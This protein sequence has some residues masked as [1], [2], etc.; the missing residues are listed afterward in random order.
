MKREE[1]IV[2]KKKVESMSN[3]TVASKRLSEFILINDIFLSQ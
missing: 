1:V 2:D 3:Q